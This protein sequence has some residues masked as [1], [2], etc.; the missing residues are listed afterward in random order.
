MSLSSD[1]Y[2]YTP[3]NEIFDGNFFASAGRDGSALLENRLAEAPTS[4]EWH[5]RNGRT[6]QGWTS[7]GPGVTVNARC[8]SVR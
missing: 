8:A 2:Y 5:H 1:G 3:V 4:P 6:R 7:G